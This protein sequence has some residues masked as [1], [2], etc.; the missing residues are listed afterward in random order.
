MEAGIRARTSARIREFLVARLS[1]ERTRRATLFERLTVERLTWSSAVRLNRWLEVLGRLTTA[2][3]AGFMASLL[4]GV[5]WRELV[6]DAVNSGRPVKGAVALAIIL[7]TLLF[8]AARSVIG[9]LRWR[10]Q[11][12]LWRRDVARLEDDAQRM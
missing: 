6:Q 11:R 10:L 3:W 7:P 2:V 5:E 8:V 1:P 12:E 9:F 4:L